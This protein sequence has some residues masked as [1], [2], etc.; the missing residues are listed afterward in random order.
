MNANSALDQTAYQNKYAAPA[1]RD[2]EAAD[3]KKGIEKQCQERKAKGDEISAF[4]EA[5]VDTGC[6][7]AEFDENLW[8][9]LARRGTARSGSFRQRAM[10]RFRS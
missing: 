7:T 3:R 1:A 5:L 8:N 10:T 4:I 2:Q 9:A 6:V